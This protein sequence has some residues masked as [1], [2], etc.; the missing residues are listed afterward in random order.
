LRLVAQD[1]KRGGD[2]SFPPGRWREVGRRERAQ[3][4]LDRRQ[5]L[6]GGVVG[7]EDAAYRIRREHGL[8]LLVVMAGHDDDLI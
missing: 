5:H 2:L 8:H 7:V 3:A 4:D 6:A 1:E